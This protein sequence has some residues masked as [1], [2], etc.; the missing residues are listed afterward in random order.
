MTGG[1]TRAASVHLL[2][3]RA[4][5]KERRIQARLNAGPMEVRGSSGS[6]L[7]FARGVRVEKAGGQ[8]VVVLTEKVGH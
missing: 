2:R 1:H 6:V 8:W 7:W 5:A 4:R 3:R